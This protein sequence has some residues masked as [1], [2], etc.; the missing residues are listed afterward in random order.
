MALKT[1]VLTRQVV[2]VAAL[3]VDIGA[4]MRKAREHAGWSQ[5]QIGVALGMARA[6]VA[7]LEAGRSR[8]MLDHIYNVS[9][10]LGVSVRELLP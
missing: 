5:E 10:A 6:N 2:D 9:L 7:N 3:Y 4:R 1:K 8:I